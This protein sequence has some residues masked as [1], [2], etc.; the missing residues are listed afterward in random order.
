MRQRCSVG[1][2]GRLGVGRGAV[3]VIAATFALHIQNS[4]AAPVQGNLRFDGAD[5]TWVTPS[6]HANQSPQVDAGPNQTV[7]ALDRSTFLQ[8]SASDNGLPDGTLITSWSL[9]SGPG[10]VEFDNS[11][12]LTT[13]A[14]F[15]IDGLYVLELTATDGD[16]TVSDTVRVQVQAASDIVSVEVSPSNVTLGSGVTATVA[17]TDVPTLWPTTGWTNASPEEEGMQSALLEQAKK[18]ALSKGGS[19]FITRHGKLVFFWGDP[20]T[21][22]DLKSSTKSL[23]GTVLGLALSDGI[24]SVEDHAQA[25][26]PAFGVPPIENADT[27]W[28]DDITLLELATHTAGFDKPGG[29]VGLLF[30]PGTQWSYSDGGMNWL[31]DVL[32]TTYATDLRTVLFAR[33]LT[34]I[35]VT[36]ADLVW[37]EN[38]FREKTLGGVKRRELGSGISAN[39]DAMARMGYL[40]LRRGEWAGQRLLPESFIE[41]V[42]TPSP[43][44]NGLPVVL[45]AKY[46]NASNHYGVMWWTN[47]DGTLVDVPRDAYWSWGLGDSL[48][49]VIPSLDIVISRAGNGWRPEWNADY[50][51]LEPF[52]APIATATLPP[53][54]PPNSGNLLFDGADDI[55]T[56]AHRA[57]LSPTSQITVEAW[58]RL[59]SVAAST[60]QDRVVS[61]AGSYELTV[62][63]GD[64]GCGFATQGHVQWI[65]TIG[66]R[67]KRVCGGQLTL[68]TWHHI[69]GTYDGAR[70]MLYV[71][72]VR[73]ANAAR[74]GAIAATTKRL[75]LGN[76]PERNRSLDGDLDGVRIWSVAL[77][78]RQLQM[79]MDQVLAGTEANLVAD[80]RFEAGTGQTLAD[81]SASAN[82][83]MRGVSTSAEAGDPT[84]VLVSP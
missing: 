82:H 57:S 31:A 22:Y 42:Q 17:A 72:G 52:L 74:T 44:A 7:A 23:G 14:H 49:V 61:K 65:A 51:V 30:E 76:R 24:V 70:F 34:P 67:S 6:A 38:L 39:V 62:S 8:G 47:E 10:T 12:D 20:T 80:Y 5:P 78:Q 27:G 26:F 71:N 83:G 73:V 29:Y 13:Q 15:S 16:L 43:A 18:Y 41:L 35:G 37:R 3:L 32:T 59:R 56:V 33:V 1:Q 60:S 19:G 69:A 54:K 58:I 75:H 63:T 68:D 40:Y 66:G 84:W 55:A 46:P 21:R 28:L 77:T 36:S 53:A 2:S 45:P 81:S 79:R 4:F 9:Q 50:S 25:L 48:V 64:T 11:E